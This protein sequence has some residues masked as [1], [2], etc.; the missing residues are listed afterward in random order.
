MKK[1]WEIHSTYLHSQTNCFN[2]LQNAST[3]FQQD[4]K[5]TT[6]VRKYF[7]RDFDKSIHQL[8]IQCLKI[9]FFQKSWFFFSTWDQ[10]HLNFLGS[11]IFVKTSTI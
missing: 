1:K 5:Q 11:T 2:N 10:I 9:L 4:C 8:Y 3:T 6:K 7:K